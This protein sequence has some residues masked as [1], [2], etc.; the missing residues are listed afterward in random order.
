MPV[1]DTSRFSQS[2]CLTNSALRIIF[3]SLTGMF[4]RWPCCQC[5][6]DHG[7]ALRLLQGGSLMIDWRRLDAEEG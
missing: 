3:A 6:A 2:I 7:I 4:P 1:K 5:S